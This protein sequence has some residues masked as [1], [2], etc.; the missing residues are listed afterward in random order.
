MICYVKCDRALIDLW[1]VFL[2]SWDVFSNS[3]QWCHTEFSSDL[4]TV[5]V[6][7]RRDC[8]LMVIHASQV[9][10]KKCHIWQVQISNR[11]LRSGEK[12]IRF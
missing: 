4:D 2:L 11:V 7:I 3:K 6:L 10:V 5:V 9:N 8:H 12:L 1:L